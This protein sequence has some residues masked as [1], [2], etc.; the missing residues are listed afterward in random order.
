MIEARFVRAVTE[1]VLE[2]GLGTVSKAIKKMENGRVDNPGG[3]ITDTIPEDLEF[4][5]D[6]AAELLTQRGVPEEWFSHRWTVGYAMSYLS[7]WA[8]RHYHKFPDSRIARTFRITF[9]PISQEFKSPFHT[10][11]TMLIP[12]D[13]SLVDRSLAE[14]L[15]SQVPSQLDPDDATTAEAAHRTDADDGEEY[16]AGDPDHWVIY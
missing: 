8:T 13:E 5:L 2:P 7:D 4:P 6:L 9:S 1:L 12:L 10:G 11:P 3:Y 14:D 15:T 16:N